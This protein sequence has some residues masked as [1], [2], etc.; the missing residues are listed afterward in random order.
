[1]RPENY[2][3]TPLLIEALRV[4]LLARSLHSWH[5]APFLGLVCAADFGGKRSDR[6]E[7][8]LNGPE[9]KLSWKSGTCVNSHL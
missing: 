9:V 7:M 3:A 8:T 4:C 6:L 2:F 5:F 1:M